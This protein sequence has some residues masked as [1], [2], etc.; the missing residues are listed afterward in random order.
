MVGGWAWSMMSNACLLAFLS[1]QAPAQLGG[2][3]NGCPPVQFDHIGRL[4]VLQ[5]LVRAH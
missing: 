2:T 3:P 4:K 5:V 1:I